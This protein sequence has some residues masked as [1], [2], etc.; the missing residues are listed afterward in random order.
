LGYLTFVISKSI[1]A[2]TPNREKLEFAMR[3]II[4]AFA[5]ATVVISYP[6]AAATDLRFDPVPEQGTNVRYFKGIATLDREDNAGAVQVTPLGTDHS[7]LTFAVSVLNLSNQSNNFGVEDI[8]ADVGGQALPVL[9][10]ERLEQMAKKRA[11][12]AQIG[13]AVA[14]GLAAGAAANRTD[15]YT[16]TTFTPHGT[17]QTMITTPSVSGQLE[18]AGAAAGGGYA[19]GAIQERLDRTRAALANEIVQ[20][21][22]VDPQDSYAGRIVIEKYKGKWPQDVHLVVSFAGHQYPFTFHVAKQ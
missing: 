15:T 17:Y 19:I 22:T 16:A 18:A 14:A 2:H 1:N 3:A 6:A 21:T 4:T 13:V 5:A 8:Q 9:T 20:T 7:R 10:R 12:W 11:M